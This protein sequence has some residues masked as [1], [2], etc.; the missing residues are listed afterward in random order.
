MIKKSE[1]HP[2]LYTKSP[3]TNNKNKIHLATTLTLSRNADK[4]AF[5]NKLETERSTQIVSLVGQQLLKDNSLKKPTLVKA[6]KKSTF[7]NT[8]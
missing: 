5:P 6:E 4:F 2:I 1:E 7:P 8:F 3:W